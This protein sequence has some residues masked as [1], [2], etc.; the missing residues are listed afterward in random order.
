M[1]DFCEKC[2]LCIK[3]MCDSVVMFIEDVYNFYH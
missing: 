1:F 2:A 3:A